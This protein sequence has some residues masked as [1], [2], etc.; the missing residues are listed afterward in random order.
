MIE[1]ILIFYRNDRNA[2]FIS[3]LTIEIRGAQNLSIAQISHKGTFANNGRGNTINRG[4]LHFISIDETGFTWK[5]VRS[6]FL[7]MRENVELQ[8][9]FFQRYVAE[10]KCCQTIPPH[11]SDEN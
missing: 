10:R 1:M 11:L 4:V 2:K 5:V 7:L 6:A 3:P 8:P 9:L